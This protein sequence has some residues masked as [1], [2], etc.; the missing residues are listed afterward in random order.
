MEMPPAGKDVEFRAAA[1]ARP[2]VQ[3]DE[4][5]RLVSRGGDDDHAVPALRY[6]TMRLATLL[7]DAAS[8]TEEPPNFCT[9]RLMCSILSRAVRSA[10]PRA[11]APLAAEPSLSLRAAVPQRTVTPVGV[12]QDRCRGRG[13]HRSDG[14][15]GLGGI[16]PGH[17]A[18]VN[19]SPGW[20]SRAEQSA[21]S[22]VNRTAFARLF[23]RTERFARLTPTCSDSWVRV[24]PR[25]TSRS[26][27]GR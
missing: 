12:R 1:R 11:G 8:A 5:I 13:S 25:L 2:A 15:R 7:T 21:T 19:R 4:V 23:L 6:D 27:M 3:V 18:T 10:R 22:V 24:R 14:D 20:Q 9:T 26:S 17:W 16:R